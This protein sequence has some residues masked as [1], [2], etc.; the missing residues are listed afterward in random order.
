MLQPINGDGV[1]AIAGG[2]PNGWYDDL[3]SAMPGA[4]RVVVD[5]KADDNIV[6]YIGTQSQ[7]DPCV[8]ALPATAYAR[9]FKTAQSVIMDDTNTIV[10]GVPYPN[11]A[12]DPT[13]YAPTNPDGSQGDLKGSFS[14]EDVKNKSQN[15]RN[16]VTGVG[17]RLSW[18]LLNGE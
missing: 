6:V 17:S 13:I 4:E 1:S 3:P 5:V 14:S 8:I 10:K 11:G 7:N 9:D 15:F 18:R 16:L 12:L 2:A